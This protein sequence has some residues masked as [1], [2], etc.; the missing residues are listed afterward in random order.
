[1]IAGGTDPGNPDP[2]AEPEVKSDTIAS[3]FAEYFKRHV[4]TE[5]QKDGRGKPLAPL[6][7]ASEIQRIFDHY[8]FADLDGHERW[9]ARLI[10]PLS[11]R[12]ETGRAYW[13]ERVCQYVW[14]R[15]VA[16]K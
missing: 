7:S 4:M 12:D 9:R 5:G 10:T 11:R 16:E 8:I 14:V 13:R 15:V 6:R 1:M 3:V 2:G